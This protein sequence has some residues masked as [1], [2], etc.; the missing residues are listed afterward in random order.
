MTFVRPLCGVVSTDLITAH[1]LAGNESYS[2]GHNAYSHLTLDEFHQRFR[3]G[4]SSCTI[5]QLSLQLAVCRTACE[6]RLPPR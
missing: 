2:L 1:N 5:N 3:L 6:A 4:M